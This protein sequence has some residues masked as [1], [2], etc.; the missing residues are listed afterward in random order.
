MEF[1]GIGPLEL[2]LILLLAVIVLGPKDIQKVAKSVG[3]GLNKMI[4]SD[5][6]RSIQQASDRVKNL[7]TELMRE[8]EMDNLKKSLENPPQE[9]NTILPTPPDD[10]T[11]D[12]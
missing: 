9:T 2:L 5:T 7:P 11:P 10:K 3:Q 12:Q 1:L 8:A 4:K 6:W